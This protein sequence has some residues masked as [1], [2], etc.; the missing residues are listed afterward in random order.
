MRRHFGYASPEPSIRDFVIQLFKEAYY[1]SLRDPHR[2]G[3]PLLSADALVFLK[4]WKDSRQ[5]EDCFEAHSAE[6][7]EVLAIEQDLQKRDY[8]ALIELDY[9]QLIDLKIISDLVKAI[10]TRTV[11]SGDVA[12]YVRQRRQG[13]W[14]GEFR[15]LYE[16]L[17]FAAQFIA[18]LGEAHLAVD[19]LADGVVRYCKHWFRLDQLYRKFTSPRFC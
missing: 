13:H 11:S 5:F 14:Y 15:H 9:F 18:A 12:L 16:S 2:P 1:Q 8:R 10:T 3:Q 4:R 7:A 17:E 19:T 6:C